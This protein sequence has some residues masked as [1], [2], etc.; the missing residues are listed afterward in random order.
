MNAAANSNSGKRKAL[1][2]T[3]VKEKNC[4]YENNS[5]SPSPAK[6]RLNGRRTACD[7][8]LHFHDLRVPQRPASTPGLSERVIAGIMGWDEEHVAEIIRRYVGRSAA[9]KAITAP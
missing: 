1:A 5:K 8:G 6:W 7:R 2:R 4:V 9:T 3:G